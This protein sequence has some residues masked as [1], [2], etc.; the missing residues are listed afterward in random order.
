MDETQPTIETPWARQA[1]EKRDK[2]RLRAFHELNAQM[3]TQICA[4]LRWD[5]EPYPRW[6]VRLVDNPESKT[7]AAGQH[8]A[9]IVRAP[10]VYSAI[11]RYQS[12]CGITSVKEETCSV[13]AQPY[14]E[15]GH[16]EA[17]A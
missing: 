8:P 17:V 12:L 1:R 3:R 16:G 9:L 7:K 10:D 13:S 11:G 14:D 4:Q 5:K 15:N 6:L 2:E